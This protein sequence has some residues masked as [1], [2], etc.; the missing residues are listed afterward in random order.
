MPLS[1]SEANLSS[2]L[3]EAAFYGKSRL[4]GYLLNTGA[5]SHF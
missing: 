2:L 4:L 3:L 1:L 5:D